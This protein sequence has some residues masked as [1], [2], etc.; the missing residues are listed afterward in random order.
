MNDFS[1]FTVG[2]IAVKFPHEG[3]WQG[4]EIEPRA[5]WHDRASRDGKLFIDNSKYDVN[6]STNNST[7]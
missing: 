5:R 7:Q 3:F 6:D 2:E 4:S 1:E